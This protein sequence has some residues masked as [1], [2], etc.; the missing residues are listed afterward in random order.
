M[1]E[2]IATLFL[3]RDIAHKAHLSTESYAQH[4]ALGEFYGSIIDLADKLTEAYQ[5]RTD[6][7]LEIPLMDDEPSGDII[8]DLKKYQDY[9][10]KQRYSA[11]K[12]EDTPIQNI[13]D[14]VVGQ[15]LSTRYKLT[16]LK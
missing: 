11:A 6:T 15:F 10:E 3:A 8:K 1:N 12:K 5:G 7:L 13:I 9:V 4:V 2:L 14:E 16:R